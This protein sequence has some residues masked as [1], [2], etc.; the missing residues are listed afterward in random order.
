MHVITACEIIG[1]IAA[2]P[3]AIYAFPRLWRFAVAICLFVV[4]VN[5]ATPTLLQIGVEFS[6]NHGTSLKDQ[7]SEALVLGRENRQT[8]AQQNQTLAQQNEVLAGHTEALNKLLDARQTKQ[9]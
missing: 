8:L 1:A 2:L 4:N 7:V 5:R 6:P 9:T 3:T